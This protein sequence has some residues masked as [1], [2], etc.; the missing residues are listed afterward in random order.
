MSKDTMLQLVPAVSAETVEPF[1][2]TWVDARPAQYR[3]ESLTPEEMGARIA[4]L[5]DEGWVMVDR[6]TDT[7][8]CGQLRDGRWLFATIYRVFFRRLQ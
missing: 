8:T 7:I 1:D 3:S 2:A 5:A 6:V 4:E